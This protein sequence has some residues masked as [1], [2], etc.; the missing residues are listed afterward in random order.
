MYVLRYTENTFKSKKYL[1]MNE[2]GSDNILKFKE[3]EAAYRYIHRHQLYLSFPDIVVV[4]E[5]DFYND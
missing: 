4:R 1:L 2:I 3:H 5:E